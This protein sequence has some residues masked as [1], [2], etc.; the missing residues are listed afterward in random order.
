M[1]EGL[2]Y[3]AGTTKHGPT[4]VALVNEGGDLEAKDG[5]RGGY[6]GG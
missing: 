4:V 2:D 6:G 5:V 1:K 3:Q